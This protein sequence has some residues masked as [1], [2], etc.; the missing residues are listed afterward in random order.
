MEVNEKP[1]RI[2]CL[3]EKGSTLQLSTICPQ[4]TSS[5]TFHEEVVVAS[6]P[7]MLLSPV[8]LQTRT[9]CGH[10]MLTFILENT[11]LQEV[12]SFKQQAL[13]CMMLRE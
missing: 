5:V 9:L 1:L 8:F 3:Q 13:D 2:G 12:P 4:L 11:S 10:C 6:N 7:L